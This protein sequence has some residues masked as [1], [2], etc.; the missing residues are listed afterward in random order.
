MQTY[1]GTSRKKGWFNSGTNRAIYTVNADNSWTST[2][3]VKGSQLTGTNSHDKYTVT[4]SINDLTF[5]EGSRMLVTFN[6]RI[7][8]LDEYCYSYSGFIP[9]VNANSNLVCKRYSNNQ[10]LVSGYATL[11]VGATLSITVYAAIQNGLAANNSYSASTT[12]TVISENDNNIISANTNTVA[13]GLSSVKGSN[14]VQLHGTM[15]RPYSSGSTFPLYFSFRLNTNTLTNGDYIQVDLGNWVLDTATTGQQSFKYQISGNIYWVPSAAT[16]VSGNIYKV[17]VYENYSMNAGTTI[18]LWVD[19]F[20]PDTYYGAKVTYI[21]WNQFKI[22]AYKSGTLSEQQVYRV[23]TEPYGH[24]SF[25]V[26]PVLNYVSASTLYEF[27]VTP[28]VSAS[29][30]DT[31]LIEFTTADG[32]EDPLFSNNLGASISA[33]HP[34]SFDCS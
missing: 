27:S 28:N 22:W 15:N 25:S 26:S 3:F 14:A 6:N 17:P 7:D 8:L 16:H 31:I 19:I 30:G 18:T 10:I 13:L 33:P 24:A 23:W 11:A 21:Q 29:A 32:L 2:S 20:S 5:P 1:Q 12:V 34:G 9:G 4:W